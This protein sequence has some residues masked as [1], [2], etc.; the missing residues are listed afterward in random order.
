MGR[1][2]SDIVLILLNVFA[3]QLGHGSNI[4]VAV[5]LPECNSQ[6]LASEVLRHRFV[7][8]SKAMNL[9]LG[10]YTSQ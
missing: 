5:S 1:L 3:C 2:R 10:S 9:A 4:G 6:P 7:R 8:N